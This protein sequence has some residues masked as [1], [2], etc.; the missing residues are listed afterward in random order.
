MI[1]RVLAGT[2]GVI[3][4]MVALRAAEIHSMELFI[5]SLIIAAGSAAI[6]LTRRP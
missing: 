2:Q 3:S 6:I 5:V 4:V 1:R